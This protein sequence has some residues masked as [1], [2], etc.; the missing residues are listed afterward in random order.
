MVLTEKQKETVW[1]K[2]KK[3][4][5]TEGTV[6]SKK[7]S[8][9][10][11]NQF[12]LIADCSTCSSCKE[13][14]NGGRG[15]EEAGVWPGCTQ[16]W[17]SAPM[18]IG[19]HI[20]YVV[21]KEWEQPDKVNAWKNQAHLNFGLVPLGVCSVYT[22]TQPPQKPLG[23]HISEKGVSL[24]ILHMLLQP[25]MDSDS[26]SIWVH[27]DAFTYLLTKSRGILTSQICFH[28]KTTRK[29]AAITQLCSRVNSRHCSE[30]REGN[31]KGNG[32]TAR[33]LTG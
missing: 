20:Y 10:L 6:H 23:K 11:V 31:S 19:N 12:P 3:K 16:D 21:H 17:N 2:R 4:I 8:L 26:A 18:P 15:E 1:E 5:V 28:H 9:V 24:L 33:D 27:L 7:L 30:L 13:C 32:E 25:V 22:R 29:W 14:V